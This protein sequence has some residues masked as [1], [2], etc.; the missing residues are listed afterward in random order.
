[1]KL[2]NQKK[3]Y[4]PECRCQ[5]ELNPGYS[6]SDISSQI[7]LSGS[8]SCK[9]CSTEYVIVNRIPR[10]VS[11]ENYA[12]NFGM[13]WNKFRKTQLDSYSGFP[14]SLNRFYSQSKWKPLDLAGKRVLDIGCGAGRFTEI[15]IEA[16]AEVF[17]VDYSS[18]V[19]ACID[20]LGHSSNLSVFQADI[21]KL[22]FP[23]SFFDYIYC[24]GVLQHTPDVKRAF[25][26]LPKYLKS[27]GYLSVDLYEYRGK[28]VLHPKRV[29]RPITKYMDKKLLYRMVKRCVPGLLALNRALRR[30]PRIGKYLT[31]LVPVADYSMIYEFS[32][33]QNIEWATMD[34]FDWLG[35]AYDQ[36]QKLETLEKWLIDAGLNNVLVENPGFLIGNGRKS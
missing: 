36:P 1:M 9:D 17:A 15:A 4:C 11:V 20:N 8:L 18:A 13:Q 16:G 34:T 12:D 2:V 28:R 7:I 30:I 27:G 25:F 31:R 33:K 26:E 23:E 24:F 29:L 32:K 3:L 6:E 10:F 14:I 22:P 21:Y 35:P 19:D 5:L